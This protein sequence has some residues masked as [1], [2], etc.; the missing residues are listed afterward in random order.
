MMTYSLKEV[1][2]PLGKILIAPEIESLGIDIQRLLRRHQSGDFGCV[3]SY[4]A[5]QNLK[6]INSGDGIVSQYDVMVG[7]NTIMI[8]VMTETDRS[9]TVIFVLGNEKPASPEAPENGDN[10]GPEGF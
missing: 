6:S 1:L 7:D 3:D 5:D 4:E 10:R 9:Y 8:C 2:F